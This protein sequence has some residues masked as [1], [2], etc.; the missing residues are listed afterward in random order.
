MNKFQIILKPVRWP[1]NG[2][3]NQHFNLEQTMVFRI[4]TMAGWNLI[5]QFREIGIRNCPQ[6]HKNNLNVR[7]SE[8]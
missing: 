3:T 4:N 6:S 2:R 8:S 5:H 7:T 1:V